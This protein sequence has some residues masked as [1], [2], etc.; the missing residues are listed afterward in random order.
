MYRV[1]I[2]DD[3]MAVR[4]MFKRFKGWESL[5]FVLADE[6]SDGREALKKL[7]ENPFDAV[8]SDIKMPGMDGIEF[9][10][11][12]RNS[13]NDICVLFLST[14]SDFSYA[15][16]G[17]RLGVFDYLTKPFS[18]ESLG[19]ALDRVKVYLDEK[20]KQKE[21]Q[22]HDKN[23]LD[24]SQVYYSKNDEKK[25]VSDILSGSLDA[26]NYGERIFEKIAQ[27]TDGDT[28]KMAILIENILSGI[29]EGIYRAIP[30]IKNLENRLSNES[31]EEMD[32]NQLKEQFINHI[33]NWV[34]LVVK[35]E[36]LQSDSL[37]RKICEF[38]INHVEEDIK[39]ETMANELFVSRDYIGKVFKQKAGYNLSEYITKVKMEHAKHLIS[40]GVYRN[41]EISERLGYKK[42]DYFSRLF[43]SYVGC[44][45]KEYRR[46]G[47]AEVG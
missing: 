1:L 5:G 15:K 45:P 21:S 46:S 26:I 20:N 31:L 27:F 41:Y 25:L 36:L 23:I 38:V 29:D 34:R 33:S 10:S 44:T 32:E 4:Y 35:F 22:K 7:N 39:M 12:L 28:R 47:K 30:W 18:E 37:I 43:K 6:A 24:N 40:K 3:D 19:E 8:I 14:H 13:G 11:E 9:L 2:V 42:V 17:I 16:Q